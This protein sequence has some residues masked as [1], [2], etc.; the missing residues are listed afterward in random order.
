MMEKGIEI[1]SAIIARLS[2]GKADWAAELEILL[3]LLPEQEHKDLARL[4]AKYGVTTELS[5][6][7]AP[8][9]TENSISILSAD[10]DLKT[11]WLKPVW[12]IPIIPQPGLAN[13]L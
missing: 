2:A 8:V 5:A 9:V 13:A 3:K 4:V 11:D 12:A 7:C 10:T 6:L 1:E